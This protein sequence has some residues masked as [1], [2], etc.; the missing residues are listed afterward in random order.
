MQ[1]STGHEIEVQSLESL[2]GI[3]LA[4]LRS[5]IMNHLHT[6]LRVCFEDNVDSIFVNLW[7]TFL[8]AGTQTA[9]MCHLIKWY[10]FIGNDEQ[11]VANKKRRI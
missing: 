9:T 5:G 6:G 8:S 2:H 7:T 4:L 10:Q 1:S 3:P 11:V